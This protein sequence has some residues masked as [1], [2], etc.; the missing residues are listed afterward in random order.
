M[1]A[2][3]VGGKAPPPKIP[4][5][6]AKTVTPNP[7]F[8]DLF[9]PVIGRD[10]TLYLVMA[11]QGDLMHGLTAYRDQFAF[12]QTE[13]MTLRLITPPR[14]NAAAETPTTTTSAV[15]AP[16]PS[17]TGKNPPRAE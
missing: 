2:K 15:P 6:K 14:T 3:T 17:S 11:P 16:V 1:L 9:D 10:R 13:V 5:P 4:N 12:A 7:E 8:V